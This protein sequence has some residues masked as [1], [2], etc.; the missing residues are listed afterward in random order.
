VALRLCASAS[1]CEITRDIAAIVNARGHA[2]AVELDLVHPLR[3]DGG[4]STGL[5][6]AEA[7]TAEGD[8]ST[9]LNTAT[10]LI[11]NRRRTAPRA[12]EAAYAA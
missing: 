10:G 6:V 8:A 3:P 7:R 2:K 9:G 4:F 12:A 5:E 1:F 11:R